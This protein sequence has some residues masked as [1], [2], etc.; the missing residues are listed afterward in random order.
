[1]DSLRAASITGAFR[2]FPFIDYLAKLVTPKRFLE[3]RDKH[4][5]YSADK[6]RRR[7]ARTDLKRKDFWT[8]A[9]AHG[10]AEKMDEE[11]IISHSRIFIVAGSETTATFLSGVTY[12]L[13]RNPSAYKNLV[14]EIR[15]SF[16]SYEDINGRSTQHLQY[17]KAV[18]DE[19]LR[20]YPPVPVGLGRISPGETVDGHYMPEGTVCYTHAWTATHSELNFHKPYEF[21]PERWIEPNDDKKMGSTPFSMG[22]RVCIGQ[23]LALLE[24]RVLLSKMLLTFDMELTDEGLDWERDNI[25]VSLWVKPKMYVKFTRRPGTVIPEE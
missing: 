25:C 12:Y 10:A 18:I 2:D 21:L 8:D 23:N 1:M 20:M 9:L 7:M 6:A 11:E 14:D 4:F 5:A 22:S 19:G 16:K 13:C 24:M 17:L 3:A 15:T